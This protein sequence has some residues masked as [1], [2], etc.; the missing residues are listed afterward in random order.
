[1]SSVQAA[2]SVI[3]G[4]RT[5]YSRARLREEVTQAIYDLMTSQGLTR[6]EYAALT[7]KKKSYISRV[8]A[9]VQNLELDTVSDLFEALNRYPHLTLGTNP[10]EMRLAVDEGAVEF[11]ANAQ[12]EQEHEEVPKAESVVLDFGGSSSSDTVVAVAA[13]TADPSGYT[14]LVLQGR[15]ADNLDRWS[16]F[17]DEERTAIGGRLSISSGAGVSRRSDRGLSIC[18]HPRSVQEHDRQDVSSFESLSHA[19]QRRIAC[20]V[21]AWLVRD[22]AVGGSDWVDLSRHSEH[23]S[24]ED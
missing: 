15:C 9:G 5:Q 12:T 13:R 10:N 23:H 11:T 16:S 4:A 18:V 7:G 14:K 24:L 22:S 6:S 20:S 17:C 1:M 2:T 3:G 21:S 8:L 19:S